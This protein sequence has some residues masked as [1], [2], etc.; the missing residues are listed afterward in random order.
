MLTIH[1]SSIGVD[2]ITRVF[3]T[4]HSSSFLDKNHSLWVKGTP[5][6]VGTVLPSD[7]FTKLS[8]RRGFDVADV[9]TGQDFSA[10]IC[11]KRNKD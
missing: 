1:S 4:E 3:S 2:G 8:V 9:V 5:P 10:A 6:E 11:I 7:H